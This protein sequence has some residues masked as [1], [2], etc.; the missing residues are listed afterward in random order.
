MSR[1]DRL[2]R[3][4]AAL[5][6]VGLALTACSSETGLSSFFSGSEPGTPKRDWG[7]SRDWHSFAKDDAGPHPIGPEDLVGADGRCAGPVA[8]TPVL[9]F[10]AGPEAAR[11]GSPAVAPA[12]PPSAPAARGVALGMTECEVVGTIG[13][14]DRVEIST[15]ERGG[16]GAVVTYLQGNRAGIYRFEEGRLKSIERPPSMGPP[17]GKPGKKAARQPTPN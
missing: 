2:F 5:V 16:R 17:S 10:Q 6:A 8:S 4:P 11:A 13:P 3:R 12:Q 9:N 1:T 14:T 7:L 15:N